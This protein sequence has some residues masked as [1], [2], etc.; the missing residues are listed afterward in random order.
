[1]MMSKSSDDK[2]ASIGVARMSPEG[3]ITLLLR[4][5]G[6]GNM[7]GDAV[8]TYDR[9]HPQYAEVLKH[10]G[11]LQPGEEKPVPPWG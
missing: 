3:T 6:E 1:M 4:A 5:E 7:R 9:S 8:L 10:V 11:G 2:P